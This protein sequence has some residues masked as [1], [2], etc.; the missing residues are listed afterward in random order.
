MPV[1]DHNRRVND[2]LEFEQKLASQRIFVTGHTGFT[3]SWACH[4]LSEIGAEVYG[5]SL[6]PNTSPSMF[7]ESG[8][9]TRT[10]GQFDDIMDLETLQ[11]AMTDFKPT[12]IL[13]LAAQPLVR[14]SYSQ[15]VRTFAVNTLGTAH[16]LEAAR[17]CE[18]V[19]G[20]VCITTDK[21]YRNEEWV[22]P[23]REN[24]RLGGKDPYSASKSAAEM[25]IQSY[26]QSYP[27]QQGKGPA[28]ATAR[29][30]NIIGGGDWAEDRL[31]PDFV[32]AVR[33][34]TSIMLRYPTATRP[35]QHVLSLVHGYLLLLAGL[36]SEEPDKYARAWNL[37]PVDPKQF[38]VQDVF[39]VLADCWERPIIERLDN[40]A[41]E[42]RALALDSSLALTKLMWNPVWST[43][44]AIR[45]TATWYS[46]FYEGQIS[47]HDITI[48]QLTR[49]RKGLQS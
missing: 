40:P 14:L 10:S 23:Y 31:V 26:A 46:R 16:V 3:G 45:E 41:P 19:A 8:L 32:R 22:W 43:E 15:P 28:I 4:W 21:V 29:G 24:D 2:L 37:G 44:Q 35:W 17:L 27:F 1:R 34:Q 18:S 7:L 36:V 38:S 13:H 30:G 5:Y 20:V 47:A 48:D 39:E 42:A 11:S 6:A 49:W 9:D 33:D 25:V 12:L